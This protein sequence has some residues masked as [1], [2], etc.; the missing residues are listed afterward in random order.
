MNDLLG[1]IE[2]INGSRADKNVISGLFQEID[3]KVNV[4]NIK[5]TFPE[6]ASGG[7]EKILQFLK[8][9][10]CNAESDIRVQAHSTTAR[11]LAHISPFYP[12]T[13]RTLLGPQSN[14]LPTDGN[15]YA[16]LFIANVF[17]WLTHDTDE[18]YLQDLY[19]NDCCIKY[20]ANQA[21][22][23]KNNMSKVIRQLRNPPRVWL[24][25]LLNLLLK[26]ML[27][28]EADSDLQNAIT[29]VVFHN[30]DLVSILFKE[31]HKNRQLIPKS[32]PLISHLI[33]HDINLDRVQLLPTAGFAMTMLERHDNETLLEAAFTILSKPSASFTI[34]TTMEG[35]LV[36]LKL[37]ARNETYEI[38]FDINSSE[39]AS[40]YLLPLPFSYL[41]WK[42]QDKS[43]SNAKFK[44]I[45]NIASKTKDPQIL[46]QT[47]DLFSY[48]LRME[49]HEN[50]LEIIDQFSRCCTLYLNKSRHY[51]LL[52]LIRELI[53]L[54][55]VTT[56]P[57]LDIESSILKLIVSFTPSNIDKYYDRIVY[58]TVLNYV[59]EDASSDFPALRDSAIK[60]LDSFCHH[61]KHE[62]IIELLFNKLDCFDYKKMEYTLYSC[63][64]LG[65]SKPDLDMYYLL[66]TI[67][68]TIDILLFNVL[69]I[70]TLTLAMRYLSM[71]NMLTLDVEMFGDIPNIIYQIV[72]ESTNY[73]VGTMRKLKSTRYDPKI[74]I[75]QIDA[76]FK[77]NPI[78]I[79]GSNPIIDRQ[80]M[81]PQLY[82]ALKL[83]NSL[84]IS[85]TIASLY[86]CITDAC[87]QIF[88]DMA[89]EGLLRYWP[90]LV[91]AD[92]QIVL[93]SITTHLKLSPNFDVAA[94][95]LKIVMDPTNE[96]LIME[97]PEFKNSF[98]MHINNI[99]SHSKFILPSSLLRYTKFILQT[100][101]DVTKKY[102]EAIQNLPDE[103]RVDF[104]RT[105]RELDESVAKQIVDGDL[106]ELKVNFA[107]GLI[108]SMR[109]MIKLT[110]SIYTDV[111][112]R[113]KLY[114]MAKSSKQTREIIRDNLNVGL[115]ANLHSRNDTVRYIAITK[116]NICQILPE[117]LSELLHYYCSVFSTEGIIV[118]LRYWFE[119]YNLNTMDLIGKDN[120]LAYQFPPDSIPEI[121]KFLTLNKDK[122]KNKLAEFIN[123]YAPDIL[124]DK[125][126]IVKYVIPESRYE[127][128]AINFTN[129]ISSISE[130][131]LR[132]PDTVLDLINTISY[133]I[134]RHSQE[135]NENPILT[136]HL[137]T[138]LLTC[139]EKAIST[140]LI[141][142][143]AKCLKDFSN[144]T[145]TKILNF[146]TL[147]DDK[148]FDIDMSLLMAF[149]NVKEFEF[150]DDTI[151]KTTFPDWKRQT[152]FQS[153]LTSFNINTDL[154]TNVLTD[155]IKTPVDP[156]KF[157][158][159]IFC[160]MKILQSDCEMPD[161]VVKGMLKNVTDFIEL[162]PMNPFVMKFIPVFIYKCFAF[163]IEPK[164]LNEFV[165]TI[166]NRH[167][168]ANFDSLLPCLTL[169]YTKS[170]NTYN[171]IIYLIMNLMMKRMRGNLVQIKSHIGL[172]NLACENSN[173]DKQLRIEFFKTQVDELIGL[174]K[175]D[176]MY[177]QGEVIYS[178]FELIYH[179]QPEM[180]ID[181]MTKRIFGNVS[182][183]PFYA[184]LRKFVDTH[185]I[186]SDE[187]YQNMLIQEF[188]KITDD[189]Q[190][191]AIKYFFDVRYPKYTAQFARLILREKGFAGT[192]A[193][194]QE[195]KTAIL[196]AKHSRSLF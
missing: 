26:K 124:H 126:V 38:N 49:Y 97:V 80:S 102:K 179:Y 60:C 139:E 72:T 163:E 18:I 45:A 3:Q 101:S 116:F 180:V 47:F 119:N 166:F 42:P 71:F 50:T 28:G 182:F 99:P 4:I 189:Q 127:N 151:I 96:G 90:L 83:Y 2:K 53:Y 79:L 171:D 5:R 39:S 132:N 22:E 86:N 162:Y 148:W 64:I 156:Q 138:A 75:S 103:E 192:D 136:S 100:G 135:I 150:D 13:L 29:N 9:A 123:K 17:A 147:R 7:I 113:V 51:Q 144:K 108:E 16:E 152:I 121:I 6:N 191:F 106:P 164:D 114:E 58:D 11:F 172:I 20:F 155:A 43:N 125:S 154:N 130:S 187:D 30:Q 167:R 36:R 65:E 111:K 40:K 149:M 57:S 21:P 1:K 66:P 84:P 131:S 70:S 153:I 85:N 27:D 137:M 110:K 63:C 105:V 168:H 67:Q 34:Q 98:V 52:A 115:P 107:G 19:A 37:F 161:G 170:Q 35:D 12:K 185:S 158:D 184:A 87:I 94:K 78:E 69:P 186:K 174:L 178:I 141:A 25:T 133:N 140:L 55:Q 128:R 44:S 183:L 169:T 177:F 142:L 195:L 175:S 76:N 143:C 77:A 95:W 10:A 32:L 145:V 46:E 31:L 54:K 62:L 61:K 117:K 15:P 173:F 93:N 181:Y 120:N 194:L 165:K 48:A 176:I 190:F 56:R 91:G 109:E 122:Y 81:F 160:L 146:V 74:L 112:R 23:V 88:P 92:K 129:Y 68:T 14:L 8:D 196:P 82:Y 188:R 134:Q 159:A 24:L 157:V 104:L 89:S 59:V 33:S 118:T 41:Q 193:S 73:I